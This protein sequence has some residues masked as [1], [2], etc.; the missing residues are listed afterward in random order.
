L[1]VLYEANPVALAPNV[2]ECV[3]VV[4]VSI[5]TLPVGGNVL[6]CAKAD[7]VASIDSENSMF[8][9]ALYFCGVFFS[10]L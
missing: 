2:N 3:G 5:P 7:T 1:E 4:A 6:V 8:F 10:L 9:I